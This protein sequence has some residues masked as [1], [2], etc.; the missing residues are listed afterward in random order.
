MRFSLLPRELV[1]Q[2][3]VRVRR[4]H[5]KRGVFVSLGFALDDELL[6]EE[7]NSPSEYMHTIEKP[8]PSDGFY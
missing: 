6:N 2:I 8:S 5:D 1:Q 7:G 4:V 3:P